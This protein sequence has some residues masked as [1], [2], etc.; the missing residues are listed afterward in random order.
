MKP[1]TVFVGVLL[2][3]IVAAAFGL[4]LGNTATRYYVDEDDFSDRYNYIANVSIITVDIHDSTQEKGSTAEGGSSTSEDS[5]TGI[6]RGAWSVIKQIPKIWQ[7]VNTLL[8][9]IASEFG[10]PPFIITAL[11]AMLVIGVAFALI[12]AVFKYAL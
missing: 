10:V 1:Y 8:N 12:S 3:G 2:F 5:E 4:A 11:Y 6:I 9:E 7:Y